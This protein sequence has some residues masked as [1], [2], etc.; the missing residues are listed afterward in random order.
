MRREINEADRD[1]RPECLNYPRRGIDDYAQSDIRRRRFSHK[2]VGSIG[3]S[4]GL[5]ADGGFEMVRNGPTKRRYGDVSA[6]LGLSA[7][8]LVPPLL[9]AAGMAF[10]DSL[11]PQGAD[12][13]PAAERAQ[14]PESIVAKTVSSARRPDAGPNFALASAG[15]QPPM[16]EQ[17]AATQRRAEGGQA[18]GVD[19]P[20]PYYGPVPVP[21][22][23]VRKGGEQQEIAGLEAPAPTAVPYKISRRLPVATRSYAAFHGRA[24]IGRHEPR[25]V[26]SAKQQHGHPVSHPVRRPSMHQR[27]QRR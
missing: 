5:I 13:Q 7:C 19:D 17:T 25:S 15:N 16:T 18:A 23:H 2:W 26:H 20:T 8:I 11:P 3:G 27:A 6:R 1:A 22:V 24:K 4:G 9:L 14:A 10:F 12:P 21:L